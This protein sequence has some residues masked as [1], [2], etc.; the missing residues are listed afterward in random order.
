MKRMKIAFF[1]STKLVTNVDLTKPENGNPGIGATEYLFILIASQLDLAYRDEMDIYFMSDTYCA[2]PRSLKHIYVKDAIESVLLSSKLGMDLLVLRA[3]PDANL[4]HY[5]DEKKQKVITWAHNR[6][7]E[8]LANLI[9][10]CHYVMRNVCVGAH[11]ALEFVDHGLYYKTEVI[12]NPIIMKGIRQRNIDRPVVTYIGHLDK[13]RGF[14]ALARIWKDI[15][16]EVPE[17]KLNVIGSAALYDRNVKLG[18][19]GIATEK[20]E[21]QIMKYCTLENGIIMPSVKFWG[22]MG[23]EKAK[24]FSETSVG[25]INPTGYETLGLSG[26]EM[27]SYGIP[28]VTINKYGQSE[29]VRHGYSGYLF[30]K[31]FEFKKYIITLLKDVESNTIMGNNA[32]NYIEERFNIDKILLQWKEEFINIL[33]NNPPKQT[34][35]LKVKKTL[36]EKI[37]QNYGVFNK[38]VCGSIFP[39]SIAVRTKLRTKAK[40]IYSILK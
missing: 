22:V 20:Y 12:Y 24:I 36:F 15:V 29:I 25:V 27:E 18:S 13:S 17:A 21:K 19:L 38:K 23:Q 4:F 34:E 6:I 32:R 1:I 5:I 37:N 2:L 33:N 40:R 30:N 39:T 3:V 26:L 28:I 14:H 8:D 16:Q 7:W 35:I 31:K 10:N 11:Q 9:A